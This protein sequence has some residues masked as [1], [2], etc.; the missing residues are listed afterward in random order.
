MGKCSNH[1]FSFKPLQSLKN[2]KIKS[3]VD[4]E[5]DKYLH[6]SYDR[7]SKMTFTA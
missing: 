4:Q 1:I 6:V 2:L 5:I 3:L 7:I